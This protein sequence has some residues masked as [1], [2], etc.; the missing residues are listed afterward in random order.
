VLFCVI[1]GGTLMVGGF[2]GGLHKVWRVMRASANIIP[3]NSDV[4]YAHAGSGCMTW[5]DVEDDDVVAPD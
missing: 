2:N 3:T 4:G 1:G 5:R